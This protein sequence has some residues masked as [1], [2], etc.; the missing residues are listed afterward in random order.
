MS[1]HLQNLK[2]QHYKAGKRP[3][4]LLSVLLTLLTVATSLTSCEKEIDFNGEQ[5][6]PKLVINS[7]IAPGQRIEASISKSFFFL[8][9]NGNTL[10][11]DD[12][13]ASLY[14]NGAF[15]GLMTQTYDTLMS[16]EIWDPN[17]PSLTYVRKI[18]VSDYRPQAGD[19]VK[20]VASANG[21][22]EVD[23]TT[24]SLPKMVDFQYDTE[25]IDWYSEYYYPYF[26]DDVYEEDSLLQIDGTLE[27]TINITDPNP[28]QMDYFR[29]HLIGDQTVYDYEFVWDEFSMENIGGENMR[30]V[31]V[32]YDD[33]VFGPIVAENDFFD[34]S[35]LDTRPEGVFTDAL[36]DGKTYPLKMKIYFQMHVDEE[37][38]PAFF[39]VPFRLEHISREYYN[40]L[41][42]CNQG[43]LALQIWSEPIQTYSNVNGGYGIVAGRTLDTLW[44]DLPLEE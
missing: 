18:Y 41:N 23:G 21:F 1:Q 9:N 31:S 14:V 12:L 20:I 24:S 33:P 4:G 28:G 19:I 2:N 8:D 34:A 32:D 5:S 37:Y 7:L 10:A 40:Y 15:L 35:D 36:F 13:A 43:D 38:D 6:D 27:L 26:Y 42:T 44:V 25:I 17:N 30:W 29:F 22:D 3:T 16:Y 11:P 39:S